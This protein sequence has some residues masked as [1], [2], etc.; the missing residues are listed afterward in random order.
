MAESYEKTLERV[1]DAMEHIKI[2]M[3]VTETDTGPRARPMTAII[4]RSQG[5][6]WFLSG[7]PSSKEQELRN[8]HAVCLT[9]SDGVRTQVAVSGHASVV[10]DPEIVRKLWSRDAEAY[11]PTGPDDPTIAAIRITPQ[12]VELWEGHN[13]METLAQTAAS[14]ISG[15]PNPDKGDHVRLGTFGKPA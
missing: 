11:L 10:H 5:L 9:F 1:W 14:W 4:E 15:K 3:L 6:I 2:A 12:A 8:D 13:R 7:G